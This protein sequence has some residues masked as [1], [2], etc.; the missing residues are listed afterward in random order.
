MAVDW[1]WRRGALS[2]LRTLDERWRRLPGLERHAGPAAALTF[3][4]GP[5]PEATP[6]VLDALDAEGVRATFFLVGEQLMAG[7]RL[8]RE[9]RERGH[10]IGLHGF[11]HDP[12]DDLYPGQ[13]RDDLARALGAIEA[14]TAVRPRWCRPPYGLFSEASYKACADL[15]MEPVYWSA[16]GLDWETVAPERIAELVA[17][18]LGPGAIV[19]LHDA[20]RYAP[21]PSATPTAAAVRLVARAARERDLELLP[22]GEAAAGG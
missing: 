8:G 1:L 3:D 2:A 6:A 22:L 10:E 5:D 14:A 13:A 9:I 4:D 19:L 15:G 16:W 20:A 7:P 17:E 11:R 12:H 21:R 18:D